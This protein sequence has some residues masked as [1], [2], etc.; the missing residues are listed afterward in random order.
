MIRILVCAL[1]LALVSPAW[2]QSKSQT[3]QQQAETA[4]QQSQTA[5]QQSQTAL[6]QSQTAQQQSQTAQQ[7]MQTAQQ[8]QQQSQ[9]QTQESQ[10]GMTEEERAAL[11]DKQAERLRDAR[12]V[13]RAALNEKTGISKGLTDKAKCVVVIPSVK[14]VAIGFGVDYGKGAMSCRLGENFNGPWSAPSMTALEG[15]NFGLQIG[16]QATDLVLLVMN[17]RGV[18]SLLK[19]KS[20]LGGDVSVAAG[21]IG[22]SMTA[23][24]DVGMRAQILSY[25]HT[26]GVF[27][28]ISLVGSTLRPDNSGNESLYDREL[29]ARQIVRSGEVAVPAAGRPLIQTLE[30]GA[31]TAAVT[32]SGQNR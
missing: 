18:E 25:S 23:A 9:K 1:L 32:S 10:T 24:T 8:L 15:G 13:M 6:Q 21:P 11:K 5:L 28:G 22:R 4:A 19:T 14:K 29:T 17:E 7:Q 12:D 30:Q 31:S 26:G 3:A 20:R 2:S 27:A 16:V